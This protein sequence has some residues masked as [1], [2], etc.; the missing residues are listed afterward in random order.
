M[1]IKGGKKLQSRIIDFMTSYLCDVC[2]QIVYTLPRHTCPPKHHTEGEITITSCDAS[3]GEINAC[4][5][6]YIKNP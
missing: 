2:G 5:E 1:Y 4:W 6:D 3:D